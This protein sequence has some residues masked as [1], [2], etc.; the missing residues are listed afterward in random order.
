MGESWLELLT[1]INNFVYF[2]RLYDCDDGIYHCDLRRFYKQVRPQTQNLEPRPLNLD[3]E[4]WPTSKS[5]M[6]THPAPSTMSHIQDS[7]LDSP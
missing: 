3:A 5:T 6:V 7:E 1:T 2:P 4:F